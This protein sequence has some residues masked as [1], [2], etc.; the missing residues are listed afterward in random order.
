MIILHDLYESKG[1]T[2][3]FLKERKAY[4]GLCLKETT[5]SFFQSHNQ[6]PLHTP[7]LRPGK[8]VA[9]SVLLSPKSILLLHNTGSSTG[10]CSLARSHISQRSLQQSRT[11]HLIPTNGK[12]A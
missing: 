12:G 5:H 1:K 7:V 8:S 10:R 11:V 4:P 3:Q 9:K 6:C 2:Y